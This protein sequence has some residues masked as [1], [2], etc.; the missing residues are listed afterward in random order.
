[1]KTKELRLYDPKAD[2]PQFKQPE[3]DLLEIYPKELC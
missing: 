3:I 1:M 2:L